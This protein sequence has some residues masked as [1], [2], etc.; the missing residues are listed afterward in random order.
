MAI[1]PVLIVGAGRM[2]RGI[3]QAYALAGREVWLIDLK[4]RNSQ[5]FSGL[6]ASVRRDMVLDLRLAVELGFLAGDAVDAALR[7]VRTVQ[8]VPREGWPTDATLV[9]EALPETPELK[10]TAFDWINRQ[11]REDAVVASTTSTLSID[12][13]G[14]MVEKP[15]RFLH[16]HWLNPAHLMP[17]VEVAVG[18]AT[19]EWAYRRVHDSLVAIGKVPVRCTASPGYIVPRIQALAMNEA[20][21][22][23]EEGAA[24]AEDI[25][26]AIRIGFGPRFAVLGLLEFID[27]GGNDILYHASRH[28]ART[29]DDRRYRAP[30]VIEDNMAAGHNGLREGRGFY[31]YT[32]IDADAYRRERLGQFM[33][34]VEHLGFLP[35]G[36]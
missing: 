16:A 27:W 34:L 19:A 4:E 36:L 22:M 31:D 35:A 5:G 28:L 29:L 3:A 24:A 2:G 11:V 13:L 23:V 18:Q 30:G 20:A 7:R 8:G 26:R 15:G 14:A 10:R 33:K 12:E 1:E 6:V 17:L 32:A 25:D 9:Y 21:R